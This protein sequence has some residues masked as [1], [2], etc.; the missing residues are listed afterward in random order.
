MY[1]NIGSND[2]GGLVMSGIDSIFRTIRTINTV[3]TKREME[4]LGIVRILNESISMDGYNSEAIGNRVVGLVQNDPKIQACVAHHGMRTNDT[5]YRSSV[6]YA[7][8]SYICFKDF[9]YI[10][11]FVYRFPG[12]FKDTD[13][14]N[15]FFN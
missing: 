9:E 6:P 8:I 3:L 5:I 4:Y 7:G 2:K 11:M 1:G 15:M 13:L 10:R 14:E 12:L